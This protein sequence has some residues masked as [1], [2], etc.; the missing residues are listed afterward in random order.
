MILV[1]RNLYFLLK[2]Y[3]FAIP[4]Y[5]E[6]RKYILVKKC[7]LTII[8]KENQNPKIRVEF[9]EF[10]KEIGEYERAKE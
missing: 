10:L 5:K 7:F 9:S 3:K 4:Y 2:E 6:I 8:E 1:S